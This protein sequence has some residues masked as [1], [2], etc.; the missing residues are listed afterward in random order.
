[1]SNKIYTILLKAKPIYYFS[2]VTMFFVYLVFL[3]ITIPIKLSLFLFHLTKKMVIKI[4]KEVIEAI[5]EITFIIFKIEMKKKKEKRNNSSS[6]FQDYVIKRGYPL[7]EYTVQTT[8]GYF[9]H[10]H[11]IPCSSKAYKSKKNQYVDSQFEK[12]SNQ[13]TNSIKKKPVAFFMH[14]FMQSSA[15]FVAIKRKIGLA[16]LLSDAGYDCWFGNIRGNSYSDRHKSLA[17]D[18]D[19]FW[20]F[21][22]DEIIQ[23]D[24]PV[25]LKFILDKTQIEKLTYVGFSQGTTIGF[26][27]L[28]FYPELSKRVNLFIAL[29]PCGS[30][31]KPKTL[32]FNFVS[33]LPV[34]FLK[35][36]FGKQAAML[37]VVNFW[38]SNTSVE[39]F[40]VMILFLI[41]T[42]FSWSNKFLD[43]KHF[44]QFCQ[45]LYSPTSVKLC[46]HWFSIMRDNEFHMFDF[47]NEEENLRHYKSKKPPAYDLSS[48]SCPIALYYGENDNL[49]DIDSFSKKIDSNLIDEKLCISEGEHID[50][51]YGLT[52]KK[53]IFPSIIKMMKKYNPSYD[54]SISNNNNKEE[55]YFK[56]SVSFS[57]QNDSLLLRSNS[58]K[59]VSS[60]N[61]NEN[62][63]ENQIDLQIPHQ[64]IDFSEKQKQKQKQKQISFNKID[65]NL[66]ANEIK[67]Y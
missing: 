35:L 20:D 41:S 52:N 42:M 55:D 8:D 64:N 29:A 12:Q 27:S 25:M 49:I 1:M 24:I 51:L 45:H 65:L 46:A 54:L 59:F 44:P 36:L 10:L 21:S 63:N 31:K 14:G 28:S 13:K 57:V 50:L 22:L 5:K 66:K 47:E 34:K 16:F 43:R 56:K 4:L 3:L 32:F 19:D 61:E 26:A 18:E 40:S 37:S 39:R 2:S 17:T 33:S 67:V 48:I 62:E 15:S 60:Y 7:E 11:R 58:D 6:E 38:R 30:I 53:E 9:L 23:K